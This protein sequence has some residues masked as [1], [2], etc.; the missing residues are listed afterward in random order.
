VTV[1]AAREDEGPL[2]L[3]LSALEAFLEQISLVGDADDGDDTG[4]V[5]LMTLHA[6]KGLEFDAVLMTG[7]EE[8]VFPHS[9]AL[10]GLSWEPEEMAEERRLCYV[11]IT[12]ARKR[13]C[14][15]L[16]RSRSLFGELMLNE[17]SRFL[18]D[19]PQELFSFAQ[20][21]S[22]KK[23]EEPR[24]RLP[25]ETHVEREPEISLDEIDGFGTDDLDQ[26]PEHERRRRAV[27]PVRRSPPS[28]AGVPMVGSRVQHDKFGEG[29]VVAT[30]GSGFNA[31]VTVCFTGLGE[32][33]I[34]ARFLTRLG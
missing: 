14:L 23:D 4:R 2:L 9:R 10:A 29:R 11:G 30:S 26:R 24:E 17:P 19:V 1:T 7:M 33:R 18:G 3:Q 12:R 5:S 21:A 13:L 6:A 31:T 32:K 25:G 8:N 34:V 16:A 27:A 15:S 20:A 22:K 28:P